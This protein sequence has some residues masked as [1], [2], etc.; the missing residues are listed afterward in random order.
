MS[1]G[2]PSTLP[3]AHATTSAPIGHVL[4]LRQNDF[5]DTLLWGERPLHL[6]LE[7]YY[8]GATEQSL[9]GLRQL[10]VAANWT[11]NVSWIDLARW[12]PWA[13]QA[14][15]DGLPKDS[16]LQRASRRKSLECLVWNNGRCRDVMTVLKVGAL[17]DA[18][19]RRSLES[20]LWLDIDC[21]FQKELDAAFWSWTLSFE[22]ATIMRKAYGPDTGI[23][24]L[25]ASSPRV[26]QLLEEA[27]VLYSAA[28]RTGVSPAG[29]VNDIQVVGLL[30]NTLRSDKGL[31]I[32]GFAIGCRPELGR[33]AHSP[34]WV[35]DAL[36]YKS[37]PRQ[38]YCPLRSDANE[39]VNAIENHGRHRSPWNIL[40]YV[41]HRKS[42][43]GP[44][45]RQQ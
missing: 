3:P 29:G 9:A 37:K 38:H 2:S 22:V 42:S 8:D 26:Q 18:A 5:R 30:M 34:R 24:Y 25:R 45:H 41:T 7:I 28:A 13:L 1:C 12:Q 40:E 33:G 32:G 11:K 36:V 19:L 6:A 44:I 16:V 31:C 20:V 39:T 23:L 4:R 35:S 43:R 21:F 27:R 17:Y 15:A 10:D 14:V